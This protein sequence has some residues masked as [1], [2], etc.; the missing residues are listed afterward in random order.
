MSRASLLPALRVAARLG[1]VWGALAGG[2]GSPLAAQAASA[3]ATHVVVVSGLAGGAEYAD[4]FQRQAAAFVEAARER[5]GLPSE[6]IVWLAEDPAGAPG[7]RGRSTREALVA[8][9][10]SLAAR[11]GPDDAILILLIGHGTGAGDE[12][13]LN[14]PG[15]DLSGA[16]LA[17]ALRPFATQTVAVVNTASAS[18]GFVPALS[19]D[20]RIVV[21]AT[22][23]AR[24]AE[25][26]HFADFFVEA[27]RD[28]GA[29]ADKDARVSLLE[30]FD[31]A[32]AEVERYYDR[33]NQLLTEHAVL[34]DDG[35]GTGTDAPAAAGGDGALAGRFYL[36]AASPAVAGAA[37]AD[38][39]LRALLAEK[40]RIERE[41]AA[42]RGRREEM[43]QLAYDAALEALLVELATT[44]RA[45]RAREG[46]S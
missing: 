22:R 1:V 44:N 12:S 14:L 28:D 13:K 30:A 27:F 25:R 43:T 11:A 2:A 20:G 41:I 4:L 9:L 39:E 37:A 26:T 10:A 15:P 33:E 5:W 6:R 38:P 45:I 32:R 7:I 19:A 31:Y 29:D 3:P 16:D 8:E 40:D 17:A 24:E 35:D 36:A 21:T 42:L 23:S 46:G 18:G 34:D